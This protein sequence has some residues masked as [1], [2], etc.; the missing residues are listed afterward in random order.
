MK[1]KVKMKNNKKSRKNLLAKN[2][3]K[4]KMSL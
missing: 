3:K 4:K 2:Q 1:N